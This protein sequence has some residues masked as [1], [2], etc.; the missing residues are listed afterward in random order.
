MSYCGHCGAEQRPGSLF[1]HNCGSPV[2]NASADTSVPAVAPAPE[3]VFIDTGLP[4][5]RGKEQ[6]FSF[7]G[8]T[9][10]VSPAMDAFNFY[11]NAYG[12]MAAK[13]TYNLRIEY[14]RHTTCLD[15][16][17]MDFPTMYSFYRTPLVEAAMNVLTQAGIYDVSFQMFEETLT[18]RFCSCGVDV[19]TIIHNFNAT[20]EANQQRTINTYNMLPGIIFHGLGGFVAATALNVA[21]SS[22]VAADVR[23]ANVTPQ[24]RAAMFAGIN[25]DILMN[26]AYSDY[27]GASLILV[28]ELMCHGENLWYPSQD[29]C[30]RAE[31]IYQNLCASRVPEEQIPEVFI[32]L[33]QMMPYESRYYQYIT[34]KYGETE[35][36]ARIFRYFDRKVLND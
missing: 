36:I 27:R 24:Q 28:Q 8:K 16:F 9:L 35:E 29:K 30:Q 12:E 2:E 34:Q 4:F 19:D 32:R 26:H 13:A 7:M 15:I 5:Y 33:L 22:M 11:Y 31:A 20:R 21:M 25:T 23:N 1:C 10:V 14:M 17:L 18:K 3:P 6:S